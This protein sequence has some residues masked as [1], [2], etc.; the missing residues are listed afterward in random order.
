MGAGV[1]EQALNRY[2]DID[3]RLGDLVKL[4]GNTP[5]F[6]ADCAIISFPTKRHW[7]YKSSLSLIVESARHVSRLADN[8]QL[9]TVALPRPGC[10]HGGL[11]WEV[12]R[13]L[14]LNILDDRFV[15]V[16]HQD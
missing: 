15:V 9:T 8:H 10:G 1:A 12:V 3:C 16:D 14:L 5:F 2:P 11:V 4:F 7:R 6:L 13:P